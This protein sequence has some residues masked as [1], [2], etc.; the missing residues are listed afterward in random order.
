MYYPALNFESRQEIWR[1]FLSRLEG[2][3]AKQL[4]ES[5]ELQSI[6]DEGINGRQ[7]KNIVRTANAMAVQRGD[8]IT[9]ED[10]NMA[11]T[12]IKEFDAA[13][14][15]AQVMDKESLAEPEGP[16]NKRRRLY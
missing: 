6:K 13:F 14:E 1:G 15:L 8:G 16:G 4:L 10:I 5:G 2:S 7:I 9:F 11:L 12:A 3:S